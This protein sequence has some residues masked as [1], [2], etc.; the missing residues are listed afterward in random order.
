MSASRLVVNPL[1]PPHAY[2]IGFRL[3]AIDPDTRAVFATTCISMQ[4]ALEQGSA[5]SRSGYH[6]EIWSPAHL[7][8]P[9]G[10]SVH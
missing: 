7:E 10:S 1:I 2:Q 6:V 5:L 8:V 3:R 9:E 4:T